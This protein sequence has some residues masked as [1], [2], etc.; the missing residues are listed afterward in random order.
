VQVTIPEAVEVFIRGAARSADGTVVV[1][2]MAIDRDGRRSHYLAT[3]DTGGSMR[4]LVRT[5]LYKPYRVAVAPDGSIWTAGVEASDQAP[6]ASKDPAADV[7]KPY[8]ASGVIRHF[9]ASGR[10]LASFVP[11]NTV[12]HLFDLTHPRN[13]LVTGGGRV[14]WYSA[15]DR[16]YVEIDGDGRE[17]DF[18]TQLP[19]SGAEVTGI[20]IVDNGTVFAA[21]NYGS[22]GSR[23]HVIC[24]LDRSTRSWVPVRREAS[25][26]LIYGAEGDVLVTATLVEDL[27]R[28]TFLRA[29]Q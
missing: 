7:L 15:E 26:V 28:I 4:M 1:C 25:Y 19:A 3:F 18:T 12:R 8:L 10:L 22:G 2:G 13:Y 6:A 27:R 14:A 23:E 17:T 16:R 24:Q 5:D 20:A 29:G 9:D 11:Q 21:V